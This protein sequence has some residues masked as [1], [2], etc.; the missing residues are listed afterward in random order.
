[1]A[2][3]DD[4]FC[5]PLRR[6]PGRFVVPPPGGLEP[7]PLWDR[8]ERARPLGIPESNPMTAEELATAK[9][10]LPYLPSCPHGVDCLESGVKHFGEFGHQCKYGRKCRHLSD[11]THLSRYMHYQLPRCPEGLRC[12]DMSPEHRDGYIHPC[13]SGSGCLYLQH[14]GHDGYLYH[15]EHY[16]H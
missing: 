14:P 12:E 16:S 13:R 10:R 4:G 1:M 7:P 11:R 2:D 8:P 9:A 6:P 15:V 5:R 3:P